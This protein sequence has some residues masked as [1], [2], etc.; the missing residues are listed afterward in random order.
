VWQFIT[1]AG[2]HVDALATDVF[3]REFA[4]NK[5]LAYV[6][7]V[8]RPEEQEGVETLLHQKWSGAY[9]MDNQMLTA[10]GGI[11]STLSMGEGV[12]ESQFKARL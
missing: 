1:L 9:L 4:K 11:A 6:S 5:M 7:L 8:Q 3:A 10:T 12:T 2:F